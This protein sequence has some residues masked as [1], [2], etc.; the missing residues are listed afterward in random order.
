MPA[1]RAERERLTL[2]AERLGQKRS[3]LVRAC[4]EL[5]IERREPLPK[6]AAIVERP[7]RVGRPFRSNSRSAVV[8]ATSLTPDEKAAWQAEA[9]RRDTALAEFVRRA[10]TRVVEALELAPPDHKVWHSRSVRLPRTRIDSVRGR[11]NWR[12]ADR[13]TVNAFVRSIRPIGSVHPG[14]ETHRTKPGP[15]VRSLLKELWEMKLARDRAA[16]KAMD[17]ENLEELESTVDPR[18]LR[19]IR[20]LPDDKNRSIALR[21]GAGQSVKRIK[22]AEHVGQGRI[23]GVKTA[24]QKLG[25]GRRVELASNG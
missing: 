20:Q 11:A 21:L 22:L 18:L 8:V 10:V 1:T 25:Q 24:L 12:P 17:A 3:T 14:V 23:E 2:L 16:A 5:V 9:E 19:L 6:P 4:V 13:K 7:H 15:L